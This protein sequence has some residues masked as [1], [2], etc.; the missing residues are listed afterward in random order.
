MT[1]EDGCIVCHLLILC[2]PPF[3]IVS[4]R[5]IETTTIGDFFS[6]LREIRVGVFVFEQVRALRAINPNCHQSH[7]C[8]TSTG[9]LQSTWVLAILFKAWVA[10]PQK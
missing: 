9:V 4:T 3:G 8:T 7:S 2:L 5:H 1:S 10:V 6:L